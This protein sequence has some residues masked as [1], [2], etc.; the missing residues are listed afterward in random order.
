MEELGAFTRGMRMIG[1]EGDGRTLHA[2]TCP[3]DTPTQIHELGVD[4][5]EE[6]QRGAFAKTISDGRRV[7]FMWHHRSDDAPGPPGE[8]R[9]GIAE[10]LEERGDGLHAWLRMKRGQ[11]GDELL[12]MVA[13]HI[14]DEFSIRFEPIRPRGTERQG[15]HVLRQEV[16]LLEISLVGEGAL[17]TRL[18]EV[19]S[20]S[21]MTVVDVAAVL[22]LLRKDPV[23]SDP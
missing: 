9:L 10:R 11:S 21:T 12:M 5:I 6:W 4:Y 20:R 22:A 23:A 7:P 2:M 15:A 16:K 1:S 18:V 19:R 17:P 8:S 13:D 3:F 14:I